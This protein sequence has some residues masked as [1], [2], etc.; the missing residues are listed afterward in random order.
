MLKEIEMKKW[1]MMKILI[2]ASTKKCSNAKVVNIEAI[3]KEAWMS[4]LAKSIRMKMQV[5][6]QPNL[7]LVAHVS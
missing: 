5:K 1:K 3:F 7:P 6:I 2:L 4:I